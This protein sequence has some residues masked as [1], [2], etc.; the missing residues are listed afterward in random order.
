MEIS[1]IS[2]TGIQ[3][4]TL[5][6]ELTL[7]L[8]TPVVRPLRFSEY[9]IGDV[10]YL[11]WVYYFPGNDKYVRR[12]DLEFGGYISPEGDIA[13]EEDINFSL[14]NTLSQ[15]DVMSVGRLNQLVGD[16]RQPGLDQRA[17]GC[18]FPCSRAT[19]RVCP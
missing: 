17:S 3:L 2:N 9:M 5:P 14:L 19:W 15:D 12:G 4:Y 11:D 16:K 13:E 7:E 10:T 6:G 1:L 18:R 8:G